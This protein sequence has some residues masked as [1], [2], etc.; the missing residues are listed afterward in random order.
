MRFKDL[1]G[2]RFRYLLV[3]NREQTKDKKNSYWKCLCD[4]G[5][6]TIV[7]ACKLKDGKVVSC[8]CYGKSLLP[9]RNFKHGHKP[10]G[11]C[12]KTYKS[13]AGMHERCYNPKKENYKYYGALGV[14]VCERWFNFEN[15]LK[16][17]GERPLD[18]SLDR[19]NPFGN[20]EPTNCRWATAKEQA[21]NKRSTVAKGDALYHQASLQ[22]VIPQDQASP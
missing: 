5:N 20:Y 6:I 11:G 17:M 19:I 14:T 4:C 21:N 13:W 12:S 7:Q 16:D 9:K 1:S 15:F 3:L 18:T 8:G 10:A 22:N 2:L